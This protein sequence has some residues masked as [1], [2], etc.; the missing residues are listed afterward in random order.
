MKM[1][2]YSEETKVNKKVNNT[3]LYAGEWLEDAI[4]I[5]EL[6]ELYMASFKESE[7]V[8]FKKSVSELDSALKTICAFLNNR[9]GVVYFGI[10]NSGNITGQLLNDSNLREISQK[11]RNKIKPQITPKIVTCYVNNIPIIEISVTKASD[12][13][14][15]YNGVAYDRS[16]TETVIMPPD[17]VKRRI[18]EANQITWEKQIFKGATI[19]F[20]NFSTIDKFLEM[21]RKAK[22]L[23]ETR[24]DKETILRKLGLI[25]DEGIT[26]AA[27]VL[28]G[29]ESSR[30]FENTLLRCGR[31]KD[32]IKEFFIDIKDYG[33]NI[34]ENLE[35]G[36][37]FIQEHIKITARIE[38]LFRVERWEIPI[39]ALREALINA[40][41][42][43][44]Y[45]INGYIYIAVYDDKIEISNPGYLMKG[46]SIKSLYKKHPSVHRN[47]LISNVLYLSGLIDNWGRGTL[48]IIKEMKKEELKPPKFQE[49]CNFFTQFSSAH[50]TWKKGWQREILRLRKI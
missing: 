28:F 8:E 23:P 10:D 44:D 6:E 2:N 45:T 4:V 50:K 22:R 5:K 27:I 49:S 41:I 31:F 30:Y 16:G 17:E 9:G 18:L 35:N 20:L 42:H 37:S 40:M 3:I 36:I 15:Y 38:G 32:E 21:A 12:D 46:L 43:M 47:K 48:N 1:E 13:I 14:Y 24:E 25:T 34:F 7:T 11:I 33:V 19:D 26:N 29:K 39:P